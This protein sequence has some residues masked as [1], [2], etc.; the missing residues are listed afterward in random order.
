M[1]SHARITAAATSLGSGYQADQAE[2]ELQH[3]GS[4]QK[5]H[6]PNYR[7]S[8]DTCTKRLSMENN[9]DL[10]LTNKAD[11]I[12][13]EWELLNYQY[14]FIESGHV[15]MYGE[16][17]ALWQHVEGRKYLFAYLRGCGWKESGASDI[18][19]I[20][21]DDAAIFNLP[22]FLSD[23]EWD[24]KLKRADDGT[25][26][27]SIVGSWES[28]GSLLVNDGR[29]PFKPKWGSFEFTEDGWIELC[30]ARLGIWRRESESKFLCA[31]CG[32][33]LKGVSE[34]L[35]LNEDLDSGRITFGDWRQKPIRRA[36]ARAMSQPTSPFDN[37]IVRK[38]TVEFDVVL[39]PMGT[40]NCRHKLFVP[41]E[42]N[43][44]EERLENVAVVANN[45][46]MP[47]A[48][49]DVTVAMHEGRQGFWLRVNNAMM[50]RDDRDETQS[51]VRGNVVV[52]WLAVLGN[53]KP[54]ELSNGKEYEVCMGYLP[55]PTNKTMFGDR[56]QQCEQPTII[57]T[58]T[59]HGDN[60]ERCS[61]YAIRV[62][63]G[64][65]EELSR[66]DALKQVA[67]AGADGMTQQC[68]VWIA[69][70]K[71]KSSD[72][73][74]RNLWINSGVSHLVYF[75]QFNGGGS[76]YHRPYKP[77]F[78]KPPH[79]VITGSGLNVKGHQSCVTGMSFHQELKSGNLKLRVNDLTP[80][81]SGVNWIA[82]APGKEDANS[83]SSD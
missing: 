61:N 40:D 35:I 24:L 15:L 75:E 53:S 63:Q 41:F 21:Q 5:R 28:G 64:G 17:V 68:L 11:P 48:I 18:V 39:G 55:S 80:G 12:L 67:H 57:T 42:E 49:A 65:I 29:A 4:I 9:S 62:S 31:Y 74:P 77:F 51:T 25:D 8:G 38:G 72:F 34:G 16:P 3:F 45:Q 23:W 10:P 54:H 6:R 13:G 46:T 79:T 60:P 19:E 37:A 20:V 76:N 26:P 73:A 33:H 2:A 7:K 70:A 32:G 58:T 59:Q 83:D 71:R 66:F 52:S 47:E 1:L 69:I 56:F 36:D 78:S 81:E 27:N 50:V 22:G 43:F 14:E 44:P 82:L 30:G